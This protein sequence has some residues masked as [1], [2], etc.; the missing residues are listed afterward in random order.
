MKLKKLLIDKIDGH[1][2]DISKILKTSEW[3]A[4]EIIKR[5]GLTSLD[6]LQELFDYLGIQVI[7]NKNHKQVK[8]ELSTEVNTKIFRNYAI[9]FMNIHQYDIKESSLSS[10][11]ERLNTTIFPCIG[12]IPCEEFNMN[13]IQYMVY[14]LSKYGGKEKKG[15]A[16]SS[17]K[18]CVTIVEMILKQGQKE[19]VF[20]QFALEKIKYPKKDNIKLIKETYTKEENK[21]IIDYLI[22]NLN[23]IN[24]GILLAIFTGARIGEICALKWQDIDFKN[25][26]ILINKTLQRTIDVQT[27]KTKI[28]I[29]SPKNKTSNRIVPLPTELI[30]LIKPLKKNNDDYVVVSKK[31]KYTEPRLLRKHYKKVIDILELDYLKFHALR[32]TFASLNIDNG[33]DTK[34]VSQ[35]L[36]HSDINTTLKIYTHVST[37]QKQRA[38]DKFNNMFKTQEE[39]ETFTKNYKGNICCINKRTGKLDFIGSI[40]EISKYLAENSQYVCDVINGIE[41]DRSYDIIPKIEGITHKNGV[42]VGG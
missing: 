16:Y 31:L 26:C 30:N 29:T 37:E 5:E 15:L 27:G 19:K 9:Y 10:Y 41:E 23:R 2:K 4:E 8:Y 24:L 36:G 42:Y 17:L 22:T 6:K 13:T 40:M 25:N 35:L 11:A 21:K 12:D 28:I 7:D 20:P 32:H 3:G 33:I 18:T 39:K 38:I 1:F 14:Y 34:T